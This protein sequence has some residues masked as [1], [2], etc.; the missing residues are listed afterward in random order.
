MYIEINWMLFFIRFVKRANE[1]YRI[2]NGIK[3]LE[4]ISQQN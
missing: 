3:N 2:A 4:I 1:L